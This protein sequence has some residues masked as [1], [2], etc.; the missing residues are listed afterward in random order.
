MSRIFLNGWFKAGCH[1]RTCFSTYH[2]IEAGVCAWCH[3]N[4]EELEALGAIWIDVLGNRY[5]RP[6]V[7]GTGHER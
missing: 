6:A 4:V 7:Q 3:R 1:Q 2:K 5:K